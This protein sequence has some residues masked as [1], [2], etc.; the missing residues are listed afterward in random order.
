MIRQ[1]YQGKV[2]WIIIDDA[3][4][5][6]TD[7]ILPYFRDDWDIIKIYPTPVWSGQNTQTRN[8]AVGIQALLN[9]YKREEIEAVFIIEDDD[10]YRPRYIERMMANFNGFSLI[11]ERNTIYYNVLYHR[12]VTNPNTIHASLFQ[13]AFKIDV[14]P[15]FESCYS[16]KFM[17]CAF[18]SKVQNRHLFYENDLAIGIKGLPGRSGIGAGHSM[19]MNMRSDPDMNYLRALIGN[20]DAKLYEGY[21][22]DMRFTQRDILTKRRL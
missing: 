16:L 5:R 15:I 21:Y 3:L 12:F 22:R 2:I 6:S 14:L 11:G 18:W 20:E 13:T 4:P 1:T 7:K 9:N 8:I 19:A 10:Y 17:D